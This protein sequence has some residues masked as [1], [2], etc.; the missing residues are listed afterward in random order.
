MFE[1]TGK[2]FFFTREKTI[3]GPY[4]SRNDA[5]TGLELYV[6]KALA[7]LPPTSSQLTQAT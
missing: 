3:E 5:N 4:R 6:S 1:D 2:W 7:G